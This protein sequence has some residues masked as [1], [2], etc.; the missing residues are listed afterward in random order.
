[1]LTSQRLLG[2]PTIG[3]PDDLETLRLGYSRTSRGGRESL[4][5]EV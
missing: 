2:R 3:D 1:M 5:A 4:A